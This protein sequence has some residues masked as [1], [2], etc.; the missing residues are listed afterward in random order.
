[1]NSYKVVFKNAV[2]AQRSTDVRAQNEIEAVNKVLANNPNLK[3][4]VSV[5]QI[6]IQELSSSWLQHL[7][8]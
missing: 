3:A 2:N 6:T 5:A 7:G 8:R 1:M 4:F